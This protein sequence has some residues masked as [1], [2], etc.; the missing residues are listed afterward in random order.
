MSSKKLFGVGVEVTPKAAG[1]LKG[2]PLED[3]PFPLIDHASKKPQLTSLP[4][5]RRSS[6]EHSGVAFS[7]TSQVSFLDPAA[8]QAP[9]MVAGS[10]LLA[11]KAVEDRRA[12]SM[13]GIPPPSPP[14]QLPKR[15]LHAVPESPNRTRSSE[16]IEC[17]PIEESLT[18]PETPTQVRD[19]RTHKRAV[20][21]MGP[22]IRGSPSGFQGRRLERDPHAV[23]DSPYRTRISANIEPPPFDDSPTEPESPSQVLLP[24][25][26]RAPLSAAH[27]VAPKTPEKQKAVSVKRGSNSSEIQREP[28]KKHAQELITNPV[29]PVQLQLEPKTPSRRTPA[30]YSSNATS[31]RARGSVRQLGT[32]SPARR[33]QGNVSPLKQQPSAF[34]MKLQTGAATSSRVRREMPQGCLTETQC[35]VATSSRQTRETSEDTDGSSTEPESPYSERPPKVQ[36]YNDFTAAVKFSSP[37]RSAKAQAD[38]ESSD[39][40]PESPTQEPLALPPSAHTS[41]PQSVTVSQR[42]RAKGKESADIAVPLPCD[43]DVRPTP[44]TPT[45]GEA[46]DDSQVHRAPPKQDDADLPASPPVDDASASPSHFQR[47]ENNV[48]LVDDPR[49]VLRRFY[50]L[51]KLE[52]QRR[53]MHNEEAASQAEE[54]PSQ[55]LSDT[56]FRIPTASDLQN[57][58]QDAFSQDAQAARA[59]QVIANFLSIFPDSQ[60][61]SSQ[62]QPL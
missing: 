58:S 24:R 34:G 2:A 40:V 57:L 17:P 49:G 26:V 18:V 55:A 60:S 48:P 9:M 3:D 11:R 43:F 45:V 44:Q 38:G 52:R 12:D 62:S 47:E 56:P 5:G 35:G 28:T 29:F 20:D 10:T 15:D 39:T 32:P 46:A 14:K 61:D 54:G 6:D 31:T 27:L 13:A 4:P 33:A 50:A 41:L 30:T 59:A 7:F 22:R 25:T 1:D 16:A 19:A 21:L 53:D 8:S 51:R 37:R 23:P 42:R 36:A